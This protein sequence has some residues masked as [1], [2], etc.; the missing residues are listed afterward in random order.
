MLNI[1]EHSAKFYTRVVELKE[2]DYKAM[3]LQI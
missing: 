3:E 1:K 2:E